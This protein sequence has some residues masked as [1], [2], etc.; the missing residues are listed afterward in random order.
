MDREKEYGQ[1]K[2]DQNRAGKNIQLISI[3]GEVE[4][5]EQLASG[6]KATKYEHLLPQLAK[7]EDDEEIEG[8]LIIINTVGGDVECGLAIAEM[9]AGLSKP[10]VSLVLGGSHSIGIPLAVAADYSMIVETGTMVVHPVR[11][12]GTFIGVN[13]TFRYFQ[14]IQERINW[15]VTHHSNITEERFT[16][17]MKE[18]EI[19]TK[20]VGSILVGKQSVDEGIINELGDLK[21]ALRKLYCMIEK[22]QS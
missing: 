14:K 1:E 19:L 5:H 21:S 13:Q 22:K 16:E 9:I 6:M 18:T 11:M 4:G 20:D 7:I 15:F 8:V 2:L 12:D 17:L 10:T 3:I